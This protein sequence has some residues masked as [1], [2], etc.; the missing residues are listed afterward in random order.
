MA[1]WDVDELKAKAD[2]IVSRQLLTA[3]VN[4]WPFSPN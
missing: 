1:N 3:S 2:Q 4:G